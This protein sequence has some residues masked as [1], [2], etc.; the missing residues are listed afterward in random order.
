MFE[1]R[2]IPGAGVGFFMPKRPKKLSKL[3]DK[4]IDQV[5]TRMEGNDPKVLDDLVKLAKIEK[6]L[7]EEEDEEVKEV[8]ARWEPTEDESSKEE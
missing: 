6:D 7:A 3:V 8:V 2:P 1:D 4:V 5:T